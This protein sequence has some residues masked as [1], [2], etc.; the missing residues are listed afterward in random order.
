MAPDATDSGI[1]MQ[2]KGPEVTE[3]N[4]VNNNYGSET[5]VNVSSFSS[6]QRAF[7]K[8]FVKKVIFR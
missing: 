8:S 1:P 4:G 5:L 7:C 3:Q 6:Q 2:S